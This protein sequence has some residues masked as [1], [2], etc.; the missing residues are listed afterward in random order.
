MVAALGVVYVSLFIQ[1]E[2]TT[3]NGDKC[4]MLAMLLICMCVRLYIYLFIYSIFYSC[5]N[6]DCICVCAVYSN[7]I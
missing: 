1:I 2:W 7:S 5:A 3:I 6:C 4:G